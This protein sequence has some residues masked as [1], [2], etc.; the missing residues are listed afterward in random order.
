ML[1]R[2]SAV[3]ATGQIEEEASLNVRAGT[4]ET[5]YASEGRAEQSK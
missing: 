1:S 5:D 3:S 4:R 2:A